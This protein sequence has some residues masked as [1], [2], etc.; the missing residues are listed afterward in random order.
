M[1]FSQYARA[2]VVAFV[3]TVPSLP[4]L[5]ASD[6]TVKAIDWQLS[7][8][9]PLSSDRETTCMVEID[10]F[11][12]PIDSRSVA[13]VRH[14][15]SLVAPVYTASPTG[16]IMNY[17]AVLDSPGG[18]VDAAIEIGRLLR[19]RSADANVPRDMACVS[20]CVLV[21]VGGKAREIE[22]RLGIHRPYLDSGSSASVPS[23][24]QLQSATNG[25]RDKLVAYMHF[26]YCR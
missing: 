17:R 15:L 16:I 8:N 1:G 7:C 25:V 10:F 6:R 5:A 21:L 23:E 22:G 18:S 4:A 24:Q 19:E 2:I 13:S 20:A 26:E 3:L 11:G 9:E 14:I 12:T